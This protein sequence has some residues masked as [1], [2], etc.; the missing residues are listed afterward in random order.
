M[1]NIKKKIVLT[2]LLMIFFIRIV[3]LGVVRVFDIINDSLAKPLNA[4]KSHLVMI[5][6]AFRDG[7]LIHV[8]KVLFFIVKNRESMEFMR[9]TCLN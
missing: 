3:A 6:A 5:N 1:A 2:N 9:A 8:I 7:L 4:I